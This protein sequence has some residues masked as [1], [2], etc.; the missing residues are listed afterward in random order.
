MSSTRIYAGEAKGLS[1]RTL[2]VLAYQ[3]VAKTDGPN[4]M[5]IPFPTD[6]AMDEDNVIDTRPFKSFLKNI[7]DATKEQLRSDGRRSMMTLGMSSA[8]SMAKVFDVGSYTVVLANHVDSVPAAL[9]RVPAYRRPK[10]S[11]KFLSGIGDL[12]PDQ[13]I[14]VCCWDG[15]IEAEPL[16]WWYEPHDTSK[17]FIPTM[18]AHDGQPPKKGEHVKTDHIICVGSMDVARGNEVH[19][20]QL[21]K[22]EAK[23]R[24]FL[25]K[26]VHGHKLPR[27]MENDDCFVKTAALHPN[28]GL[29]MDSNNEAVELRR[30]ADYV[31]G[32]RGWS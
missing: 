12:Y 18:D 20:S 29:C 7:V 11:D 15:E 19:Y 32:M 31:H 27:T 28:D 6:R 25:P 9:S 24:R 5:I 30:G 23:V 17:L 22:M 10:M 16:M 2:H 1:G 21:D 3:N 8:K 26:R 13:P 4:A 14:A